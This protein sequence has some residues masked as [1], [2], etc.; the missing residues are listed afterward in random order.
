MKLNN[1]IKTLNFILEQ[2]EDDFVAIHHIARKHLNRLTKTYNAN[3]DMDN[4]E[5]F[6]KGVMK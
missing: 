5:N 3:D 4:W 1:D 6:L 2:N